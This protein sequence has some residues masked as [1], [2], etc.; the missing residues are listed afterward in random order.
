M[1]QPAEADGRRLRREHNRELVLRALAELFAEGRYTPTSRQI[2]DR[3]GLSLRSLV[4]YF[5]DF[6]DLIRS[7]IERQE[8]QAL[9]LVD[10][11]C[12][13]DESSA[14]KV[15]A[16]VEARVRLYE[17]IAPAA[18]AGRVCAHRQPLV[19]EE[20]QR[21]R[22]FFHRQL[23]GIFA[24]ELDRAGAG[25][26]PALDVV[27]SFE[28]WDLMRGAQRLSRRAT[29]DALVA[30]AEALLGT[31]VGRGRTPRAS[32]GAVTAGR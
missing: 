17:A 5:D 6:D 28:S 1:D 8:R 10:V 23:A 2:A 16:V 29:T 26:L 18:R 3:A 7:T 4:R 22:R 13:P 32:R 11:D 27:L 24:P 9:A 12:R 14:I 25:I 31:D 19:A 15:R 30:A 21:N 20:L